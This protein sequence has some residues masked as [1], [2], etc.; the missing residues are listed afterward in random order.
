MGGFHS[1]LDGKPMFPLDYDDVLQLVK[2]CSLV[3]PTKHELGDKSK[4]DVLSKALAYSQAGW[5]TIHCVWRQ[6]ENVGITNLEVMTAAYTLITVGMYFAWWHK[7]LR[8]RCPIRVK[9]NRQ[10]IKRPRPFKW[11]DMILYIRGNQD[12]LTTLSGEERVPTFWSN[13][14][15]DNDKSMCYADIVGLSVAIFFGVGHSVAWSYA[16]P[17]LVE[18]VMWRSCTLAIA[19]IPTTMAVALAMPDRFAGRF[20]Q[21]ICM[22]SGALLYIIARIFLIVLSITTLRDLPLAAYQTV[23]WSTIIPHI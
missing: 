2:S 5:F 21:S 16:F 7:P 22:T 3:P 8:V 9:G 11:S 1:Y 18:K 19:V 17:T 23:P 13:C 10:I 4:R 12:R 14:T 20:I 6:I 15:S